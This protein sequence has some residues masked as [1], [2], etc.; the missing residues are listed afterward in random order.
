MERQMSAIIGSIYD[1]VAHEERWPET[2]KLIGDQ[3]D[4]FLT[5]L[6]VFDTNTRATRLAQIACDDPTAIQALHGHA[7]DIPFFH[8][9]H[10]MEIDQPDTLE[11]MFRLYGPD[12]EEVW[13][14]GDLYRNFHSRF[15]VRNSIDMAVLKR[16]SRVGTIN[17]SVRYE[18]ADPRI[19]A[20]VALLGPHIRRAVSIHDMFET[21]RARSAVPR[22]VIDALQHGVVIV[23][24]ELTIVYANKAAEARLRDGSVIR[25]SAGRLVASYPHAHA[26]L[27]RAILTGRRDEV[28]LGGSG[29][30]VPL[31]AHA[32]PAVAH[33]LPLER[34]RE[35][36]GIE[37]NAAAAIFIA[38]AGVVTQ[39]ATEAIAAL[40]GLTPTEKQ[41]VNYVSDGL[42]RG[43]IAQA[44]GV[45]DGT[46]KSQLSAIFDKTGVFDQ[47]SLQYL[48]RELTPP[49]RR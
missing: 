19:F 34:R 4:G 18:P 38:D 37:S 33:V 25:A 17:I 30:D 39:T 31:G 1:C 46:V 7:Q 12:G 8:L 36:D 6:A 23:T 44:Q 14:S 28:S 27:T 9:L 49:V 15:G 11:R 29:I 22:D 40:F 42:N 47:R 45:A 5:T 35:R 32:R 2:L 13:K 3:V 20:L 48:I 26:A 24:H 10:K 43:E 16:P 21:E 41:I